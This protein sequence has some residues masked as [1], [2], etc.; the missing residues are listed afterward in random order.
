MSEAAPSPDLEALK[1]YVDKLQEQT[2]KCFQSS[3]ASLHNKMDK[4][5]RQIDDVVETQK[6]MAKTIQGLAKASSSTRRGQPAPLPPPDSSSPLDWAK[7]LL[8]TGDETWNCFQSVREVRDSLRELELKRN[9]QTMC[10]GGQTLS[11]LYDGQRDKLLLAVPPKCTTIAIAIGRTDLLKENKLLTL[12]QASLDTVRRTNKGVL[13]TLLI[14]LKTMIARLNA[15]SK[16]VI[17]VLPPLQKYKIEVFQHWEEIL[18]EEMAP[19]VGPNLQILNLPKA[20][21]ESNAGFS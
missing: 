1:S 7:N 2:L 11:A 3:C 13:Q 5:V 17:L 6:K 9:V 19:L 4:L 16:R 14:P 15:Q 20:M 21:Y 8:L 18:L 12:R 10:R